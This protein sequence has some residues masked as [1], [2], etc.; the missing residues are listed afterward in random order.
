MTAAK[1]RSAADQRSTVSVRLPLPAQP[2][3]V[4]RHWLVV[5]LEAVQMFGRHLAARAKGGVQGV[6]LRGG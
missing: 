4:A 5:V 1:P 6:G 3:A 2:A